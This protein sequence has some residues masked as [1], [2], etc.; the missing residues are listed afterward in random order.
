LLSRAIWIVISPYV[1]RGYVDHTAYDTTSIPKF[2]T[3][4]FALE[5]LPSVRAQMGDLSAA[6]DFGQ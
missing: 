1:R 2:I 6:F 5:P 3:R 4:R